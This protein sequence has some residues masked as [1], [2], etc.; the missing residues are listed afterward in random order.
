MPLKIN[1]IKFFFVFTFFIFQG[2]VH[3]ELNF[4][5]DPDLK[6]KIKYFQASCDDEDIKE[7]YK[8]NR[9]RPNRLLLI[10]ATDPLSEGQKQYLLDNY[11]NGIDWQ[12]KGEIFSMVLL[13]NK[14]ISKLDRVTLCS[15]MREDQI[16][17]FDAKATEMDRINAYK[18]II[19]KVFNKMVNKDT[20]ANSTKLIETL[21]AIYTNKRF[22]FQEGRRLLLITSDLLQ[23]S[24][25][26]DL[27][28]NKGPCPKFKNTLQKNKRWFQVSK[29]KLKENDIVEMYYF[30]TKCKVN[31]QRLE[32]WHEY[33]LFEGITKKNL[34]IRAEN[35]GSEVECEPKANV[36]ETNGSAKPGGPNVGDKPINFNTS[37]NGLSGFT[38]RLTN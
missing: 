33:F 12:N 23:I 2:K 21:Y 10:D 11:I 8:D 14:D 22:N 36:A 31:I 4:D 29:L 3:A 6:Q 5:D 13:D 18:E 38:Q 25:E 28:C 15:P 37:T 17:F 1:I 19:V 32:W 24:K 27:R 16:S 9:S 35:G 30:Q 20:T 7:I 26:V 34:L